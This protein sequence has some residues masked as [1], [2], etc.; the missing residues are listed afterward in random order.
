MWA[1]LDDMV[2]MSEFTARDV[3]KSAKL[4]EQLVGMQSRTGDAKAEVDA[5]RALMERNVKPE[6]QDAAEDLSAM[7]ASTSTRTRD[8]ESPDSTDRGTPDGHAPR[9]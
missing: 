8:A 5:L 1:Y 3:R 7:I 9:T 4:R 6:P 2:S